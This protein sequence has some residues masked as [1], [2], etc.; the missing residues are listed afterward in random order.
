MKIQDG[1]PLTSTLY[2]PRNRLGGAIPPGTYH[3]LQEEWRWYGGWW[4]AGPQARSYLG[5]DSRGSELLAAFL[6]A[7]GSQILGPDAS[8]GSCDLMEEIRWLDFLVLAAMHLLYIVCFH[9]VLCVRPQA[10]DRE[11]SPDRTAPY[12]QEAT[13]GDSQGLAELGC[14]CPAPLPSCRCRGEALSPLTTPPFRR[15]T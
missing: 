6:S 10:Q 15:P 14:E 8:E 2:Y 1:G 3:Y 7:A 4:G 11:R 5:R 12:Q 9:R 13:P